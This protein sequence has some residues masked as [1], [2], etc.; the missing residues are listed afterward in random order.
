MPVTE[1]DRRGRIILLHGASSSGK[2]TLARALQ[3]A[4]P[5]PFWHVSIDHIRDAGVLPSARIA[6]GEFP[7]REM[8]TAFFDGFHRSLAAYASAGNNLI[9]EHIRDTENWLGDLTQLLAP[10][11]VFFV[12]LHCPLDE[13]V[14]REQARGDRRIGSAAEDHARIHEGLLY[15]LELSSDRSPENNATRLIAAWQGRSGPTVF[16]QAAASGAPQR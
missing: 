11:D 7:W 9:V 15:D 4:L 2:S 14:R 8:R 12:G 16:A 5:Q 6:S 13:L 1:S 10:F 3:A